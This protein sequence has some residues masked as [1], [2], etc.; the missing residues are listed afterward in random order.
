MKRS[1]DRTL[2][3][4]PVSEEAFL[5]SIVA[6]PASAAATRLAL[7]DWLEEQGDA[8]AELVRLGHDPNFRRSMAAAKR[9]QRVQA[10]SIFQVDTRI[11]IGESTSQRA[12]AHSPPR[13]PLEKR[14]PAGGC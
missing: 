8:R 5:Q 4:A 12:T 1:H 2:S 3:E 10:V 13:P 11:V 6:D 9:N 14:G 7:A